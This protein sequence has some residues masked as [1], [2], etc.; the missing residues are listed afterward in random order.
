MEV[1][2]IHPDGGDDQTLVKEPRGTIL[3]LDY[4]PVLK[5]VRK[6]PLLSVLVSQL[7]QEKKKMTPDYSLA[8][9]LGHEGFSDIRKCM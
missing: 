3:A 7:K 2:Q 4:D 9:I 6:V 1:R 5:H 8:Q